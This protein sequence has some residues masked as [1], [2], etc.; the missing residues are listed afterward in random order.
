MADNSIIVDCRGLSPA[1]GVLRVKQAVSS[2]P[3]IRRVR[4]VVDGG[5][6]R[7]VLAEALV[8]E[9]L[10]VTFLSP[11]DLDDLGDE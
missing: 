7:A 1:L 10:H 3:S 6:E 4:L 8:G 5:C 2:S 9:G 11:A